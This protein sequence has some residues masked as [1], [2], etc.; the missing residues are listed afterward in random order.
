MLA[1]T[2]LAI[3]PEPA[4]LQRLWQ[5]L[6]INAGIN[7]Y[8]AILD[9][10]N[11]EI[12]SAPLYQSTIDELC[13]ELSE[14]M[15]AAVQ[16]RQTPGSLRQR[17]EQVAQNTAGNTSSMRADVLRKRQTEIDFINGYLAKL[18]KELGIETPVNQMLTEQ[19]Q[20]LSSH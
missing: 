16:I 14:L 5:K 12:L 11:G 4:I 18:G 6:I 10:P 2:G 13:Q 20:Q 3:H 19:V 1:V 15:S 7:P 17:I 9:C 8:T